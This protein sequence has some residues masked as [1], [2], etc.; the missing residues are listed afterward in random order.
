MKGTQG[1]AFGGGFTQRDY[2][3]QGDRGDQGLAGFQG[4]KGLPGICNFTELEIHAA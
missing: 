2:G 1:E 3:E 4:V